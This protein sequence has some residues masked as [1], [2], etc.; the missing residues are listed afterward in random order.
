[1][2]RSEELSDEQW[3]IV[4]VEFKLLNC[5]SIA[6]PCQV[7]AKTN[8]RARLQYSKICRTSGMSRP[9]MLTMP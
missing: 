6:R 4:V 8:G 3:E 7:S 9:P 1:M 2:T 5:C